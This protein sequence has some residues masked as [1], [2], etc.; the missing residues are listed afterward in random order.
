MGRLKSPLS[1][2]AKIN[3]R[4]AQET[5]KA[6]IDNIIRTHWGSSVIVV[7]DECYYPIELPAF[8]AE[9]GGERVGVLTF[10]LKNEDLEVI[11]L[12]ALVENRGVGSALIQA[13]IE[14]ARSSDCQQICL[15]T[16]NDN[17]KAIA[18]YK[19]Q[20]F[21]IH[22]VHQGAIN[23]ARALKPEI[24]LVGESG[25]PICDEIEMRLVLLQ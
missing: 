8:V 3:C 22:R 13:V 12:N 7:H 23:R 18:F 20:G 5:D 15:T 6:W 9:Q 21:K 16:S 11:S 17:L 1:M 25:I 2:P 10:L 24:P 14:H 19:K 4:P